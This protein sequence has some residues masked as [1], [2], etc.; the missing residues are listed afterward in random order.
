MDKI[1]DKAAEP[2]PKP[3]STNVAIGIVVVA[4][5]ILAFAAYAYLKLGQ[6]SDVSASELTP[7]KD[8]DDIDKAFVKAMDALP[9]GGY[10]IDDGLL[11]FD[12]FLMLAKE[13]YYHMREKEVHNYNVLLD[14]RKERVKKNAEVKIEDDYA[15]LIIKAMVAD[16][17]QR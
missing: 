5:A 9:A 8:Y 4:V 10:F 13:V 7:E 2:I 3:I 1:A 15:G 16:R 12:K 11:N 14:A 17:Q 6:D